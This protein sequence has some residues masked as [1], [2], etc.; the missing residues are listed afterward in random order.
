MVASRDLVLLAVVLNCSQCLGVGSL[1]EV[2]QV[3]DDYMTCQ[4]HWSC[5]ITPLLLYFSP[6]LQ[7]LLVWLP[8]CDQAHADVC[9]S[10]LLF[11][12]S[13]PGDS[14]LWWCVGRGQCT[15]VNSGFCS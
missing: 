11:D 15:Q 8:L 4:L 5:K 13:G 12:P 7:L 2:S 14:S 10:C 6:M 1:V 3:R 9:H